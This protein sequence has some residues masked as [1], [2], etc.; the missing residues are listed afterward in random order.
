MKTR[1]RKIIENEQLSASDF[2]KKIEI[3]KSSVSHILSGRN[4]PSLEVVQKILVAFDKLNTE[5][6]IFGTG[7]MYKTP[8]KSVKKE[9]FSEKM[10]NQPEETGYQPEEISYQ[11]NKAGYQQEKNDYQQEETDYQEEK[12]DYQEEKTIYQQKEVQN[13]AKRPVKKNFKKVLRRQEEK[14]D[15]KNEPDTE[16]ETKKSEILLTERII[17]FRSDKTFIEYNPI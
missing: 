15:D 11:R 8:A 7:N 1:I 2:A 9:L 3:Q 14:I 13:I 16:L 12:I 10:D 17:I 5:W 4:K 6:L